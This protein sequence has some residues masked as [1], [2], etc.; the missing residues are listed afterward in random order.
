MRCLV[1]LASFLLAIGAASAQ[2]AGSA[3]PLSGVWVPGE[4]LRALQ[5]ETPQEIPCYL[6]IESQPTLE[7]LEECGGG[8]S[9]WTGAVLEAERAG[10]LEV[11]AGEQRRLVFRAGTPNELEL[12]RSRPGEEPELV[13]LYRLPAQLEDRLRA[14]AAAQQLLVGSW[15]TEDGV[16]VRF[17]PDGSYRIAQEQGRYRLQPGAPLPGAWGVL[18]LEPASPG[19]AAGERIYLLTGAGR[20]VGLA[21][22]PAHLV[23]A[24]RGEATG[25]EEGVQEQGVA[26]G[27]QQQERGVVPGA[28]GQQEAA[29]PAG[30]AGG[31]PQPEAPAAEVMPERASDLEVAIWLGRTGPGVEQQPTAPAAPQPELPQGPAEEPPPIARPIEPEGRCGCG[32]AEGGSGLAL[33]ALGGVA[34]RRRRQQDAASSG[35]ST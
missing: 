1:F 20:R 12:I 3:A 2:T 35:S 16:E 33:L 13:R 31:T 5:A 17:E 32:A 4:L 8:R 19:D 10:R 29:P 15:R 14:W 28:G 7:V 30:G 34:L 9:R 11:H 26:P 24:L 25:Q 27:T 23:P 18:F 6:V 21:L 22:P